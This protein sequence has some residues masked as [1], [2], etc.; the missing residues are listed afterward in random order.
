MA[1]LISIVPAQG[2]IFM[3]GATTSAI[4]LD[5]D[6]AT[7]NVSFYS[8]NN[9][10]IL[11]VNNTI[12]GFTSDTQ[13]HIS[14]AL[15]TTGNETVIDSTGWK[16]EPATGAKGVKGTKGTKGFKYGY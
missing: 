3:S 7:N 8:S 13:V 2:K 5:A 10:Q 4:D 9:P 1:K 14:V 11:R 15:K 12:T 16:G 6:S